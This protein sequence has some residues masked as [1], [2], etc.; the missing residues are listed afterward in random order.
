MFNCCCRAHKQKAR[1]LPWKL[2][3]HFHL[4]SSTSW[5]AWLWKKCQCSAHTLHICPSLPHSSAWPLLDLKLIHTHTL[6][7]PSFILQ[8]TSEAQLIRSQIRWFCYIL[9]HRRHLVQLQS[10]IANWRLKFNIPEWLVGNGNIVLHQSWLTF[11]G[12]NAKLQP[13]THLS[14]V[15]CQ[16]CN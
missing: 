8:K 16:H 15:K 4:Y 14:V 7:I 3:M 1:W 5:D 9:Q 6:Q 11:Q 10:W 12:P 13:R 2:Y